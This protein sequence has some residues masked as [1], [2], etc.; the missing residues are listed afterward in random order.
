MKSL[1]QAKIKPAKTIQ[2]RSG[3]TLAKQEAAN[4]IINLSIL[5]KNSSVVKKN[6]IEKSSTQMI[7]Y[8][9]VVDFIGFSLHN[10]Q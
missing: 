2:L 6:I 10:R 1:M 9:T 5:D 4:Q 8:Q 3:G 7:V